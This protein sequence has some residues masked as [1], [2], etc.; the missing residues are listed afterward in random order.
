MNWFTWTNEDDQE[1]T[2]VNLASITAIVWLDKTA[3]VRLAGFTVYVKGAENI[4]N[5]CKALGWTHDEKGN[6]RA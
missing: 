5:F 1:K 6:P 4:N 2:S 3:V